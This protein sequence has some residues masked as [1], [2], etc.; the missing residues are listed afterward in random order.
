[1][2]DEHLR[3]N[4]SKLGLPLFETDEDPD[5]HQTLAEV[6]K[7][8]DIRLRESFPVLLANSADT[9]RF[10]PELVRQYLSSQ[11]EKKRFHCMLLLS[12]SL[13]AFYQMKFTW[14][15]R[16]SKTL[17]GD[18][19]SLIKKWKNFLAHNK[20]IKFQDLEFDPG[21]LKGLFELYFA[22]NRSLIRQQKEKYED[23][24]TEYALSQI[25][26]PK[27]KELFKKRL[28]GL[29]MTKTEQEYYSRTVRKKATALA[30]PELH[31]LARKLLER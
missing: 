29:P 17:S 21:R 31:S 7:S 24:S 16:F 15:S 20:T 9:R 26:S 3:K 1:M 2:T 25:F 6:V 18:E 23:Y 27:Q 28:E 13:Y 22:H 10:S 5:F 14:L 19:K 4:L 12:A 11:K 30:N 8:R